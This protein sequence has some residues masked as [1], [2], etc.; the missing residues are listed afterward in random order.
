MQKII[1]D[2]GGKLYAFEFKWKKDKTKEPKTFLESYKNS[3]FE[4]INS[5]NYQKFI[6]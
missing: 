5:N 1:D 3:E 2:K 6:L 4:V